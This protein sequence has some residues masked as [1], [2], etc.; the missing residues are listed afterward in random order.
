MVNSL[1][2]PVERV[3]T[4]ARALGLEIAVRSMP[5]ST[6]TAAEAASAVGCDL[7][8]IVKSLVFRG[9]IGGQPHLLLVAGKNRVDQEG[10]A[11]FAGEPLDRADPAFVR[12]TTGFSIG[13]IPPVG[14]RTA[15]PVWFDRDLLAWDIV[16]AAAGTADTMFAVQPDRLREVTGATV[17]SVA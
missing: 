9:R 5:Q 15:L 13:G 11:L 6:H 3:R 14:L 4:A 16:W 2:G 17:V 12:E 1:P 7:G 10:A 8:Q